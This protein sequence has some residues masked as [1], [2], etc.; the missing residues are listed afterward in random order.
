M[1]KSSSIRAIFIHHSTGGD[2]I[3]HG[4]V[5]HLFREATPNIEFWDHGYDP[6]K[7]KGYLHLTS[8]FQLHIYGLRD[9]S[10]QLLSRSFHIPNHNTDPD[11]LSKLFSQSVTKPP[12]NALSEILEF[13]TIIFKSCFP[14]TRISSDHQL[15]A[16]QTY[17]HI[18]RDTIDKYPNKLFIPMTPPP[19]RAS[20]TN[21][22]MADRARQYANWLMSEE[23]HQNRANLIP[24]NYF[25]MLAT[26][27]NS[28]EPNVL[29]LEF[30]AL[31]PFDSHPN[32]VAHRTIA[33]KYVDFIVGAINKFFANTPNR[34]NPNEPVSI[35]A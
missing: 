28:K 29:R 11:G 10:G 16:Y 2:L 33:P 32:A 31:F 27:S 4:N 9:E 15:K 1:N 8:Q 17:Y 30:C 5:R 3:K 19:L 23:Y 35:L 20:M 12:K 25:D 24:F 18:I 21:S 7:I 14:T 26:P 13:D 34:G 6:E 22:E